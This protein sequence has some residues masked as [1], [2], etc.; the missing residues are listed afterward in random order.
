MPV[1]QHPLHRSIRAELPHT[2]PALGRDDQAGTLQPVV[3]AE[4]LGTSRVPRKVFSSMHGV[5][6][7]G[8]SGALPKRQPRCDLRLV[9]TASASRTTRSFRPGAY[10][11]RL[12]TRP[13]RTPVDASATA[14]RMGTHCSEPP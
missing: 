11:S 9:S 1:T 4:D 8:G 2:A 12:D 13:T 6:E 10:I 3:V 14:L 7:A 5:C